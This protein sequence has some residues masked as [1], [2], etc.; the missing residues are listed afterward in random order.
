MLGSKERTANIWVVY[1]YER[2]QNLCYN[3]GIIGHEQKHC[4]KPIAMSP[5][6][7][8]QPKYGPEFSVGAPRTIQYL[9]RDIN[10]PANT[11]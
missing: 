7:P 3:Y 11:T 6:N 1:R 4:K 8:L 10:K 9:G 2:L 5:V